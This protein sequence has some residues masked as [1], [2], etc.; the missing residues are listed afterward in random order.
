MSSLSLAKVAE[1]LPADYCIGKFDGSLFLRRN[2]GHANFGTLIECGNN[3]LCGLGSSHSVRSCLDARM[4]SAMLTTRP[5][6][7]SND[8]IQLECPVDEAKVVASEL[9]PDFLHSGTSPSNPDEIKSGPALISRSEAGTESSILSLSARQFRGSPTIAI[10][11]QCAE[12]EASG[13]NVVRLSG[14]E[15]DFS[16]PEHICHAAETAIRARQ[17]GYTSNAGLK[18]LRQTISNNYRDEKHLSYFTRRD[19]RRLWGQASI[20][21]RVGRPPLTRIQKLSLP[22]P[23]WVSFPEMV[24]ICGGRSMIVECSGKNGWKIQPDQ[25]NAAITNK[26][27]WLV[28][29]S[30]NNPTGAV[31][32]SR[33]A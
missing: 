28:L 24:Q 13:V 33:R 21:Q 3:A 2:C 20:I 16:T 9:P 19:H 25:L 8:S 23:F 11:K 7:V 15:P 32:F 14:G 1:M 4:E 6:K 12:L 17:T 5:K 10:A 31:L 27:K 18:E 22:A 29:N 26:T 30:P